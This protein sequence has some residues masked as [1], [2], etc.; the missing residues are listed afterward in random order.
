MIRIKNKHLLRLA[1]LFAGDKT[2]RKAFR[3]MH[4]PESASIQVNGYGKIYLPHYNKFA[5]Y[6]SEEPD[7]YNSAGEHIRTLFF[8]DIHSS[9]TS[10]L[11]GRRIFLDKYNFGL[12]NHLYTHRSMLET[13]GAPDHR[14]GLLGETP[15]IVPFDYRLFDYYPGLE[16]DFDLIFTYNQR[17]LE[18]LPNARFLPYCAQIKLDFHDIKGSLSL[19]RPDAHQHKSKDLSILSSNKVMCALHK[20]RLD[21]AEYAKRNSICDTFGTFDGGGYV[22]AIDTLMPYR[23]SVVV[24]NAIEECLFT[25]KLTNCFAC[26]TI[27]LYIGPKGVSRFFNEDGIIRVEKLSLEGLLDAARQCSEWEY[28]RRLPAVL[29]NYQRVQQFSNI[30]DLMYERYLKDII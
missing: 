13:M 6:E 24:E 9:Y 4:A 3:I 17:L 28:L 15:G 5:E 21:F 23:F 29:D 10:A 26:Q 20:L 14:F 30:I 16:K 27:P 7:I 12:K 8:R 25:E 11:Q 1:S 2:A 22:R 18:K 19:M